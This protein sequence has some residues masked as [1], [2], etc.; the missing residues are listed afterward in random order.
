M[1][2]PP[3]TH[4]HTGR[5]LTIWKLLSTWWRHQMETFSALLA[6]CAG[7]SPVPVN[8]PHKG[9]WR[10]ALMFSLI[11]AWINGW[12]NYREA[13]DLRR[14][15]TH[16]DVIVMSFAPPPPFG[17]LCIVSQKTST[18]EGGR[19]ILHKVGIFWV[20]RRDTYSLRWRHNGRDSVSN[21]QPHHCLLNRLFGRRSKK[22][23]NFR[24][25]PTNSPHKWPVTRK[26]IPSVDV[27]MLTSILMLICVGI[28]ANGW[29]H[30]LPRRKT[31]T[32]WRSKIG[33]LFSDTGKYM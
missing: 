21:H 17:V 33:H 2:P 6:I 28:G 7:N 11:C 25:E 30:W 26:M 3:P 31:S 8:S 14:N 12:V 24:R 4:T 18:A 16:Y 5:V 23:S 9:Q 29:S 27:I 13:G 1:T 22:T 20:I 10:G 19:C 32:G 15:R